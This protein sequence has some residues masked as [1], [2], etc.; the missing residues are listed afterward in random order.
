MKRLMIGLIAASLVA[1]SGSALA[2]GYRD[3]GR[4][5]SPPRHSYYGGHHHSHSGA[6]LLGGVVLGAVLAD[7]FYRPDPPE[8]VYVERRP[9][10]GP[11]VVYQESTLAV[12]A[13]R[14]SLLRDLNGNCFETSNDTDGRELRKQVPASECDW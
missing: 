3:Y 9:Y 12:P 14:R 7:A 8:V 10:Y 11:R 13:V 6:Y 4:H 1:G 5:Y 2:G